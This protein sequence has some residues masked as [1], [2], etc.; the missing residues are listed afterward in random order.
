MTQHANQALPCRLLLFLQGQAHVCQQQQRMRHAILAECGF[1][2]QPSRK[3]GAKRM[4]GV[5]LCIQQIFKPQLAGAAADAPG[6]RQAQQLQPGVVHQLQHV[7]RSKA[8]SGVCI[9]SNMRATSAVD[10]RERTRCFC[11]RSASAFTSA[12]SSP[13]HPALLRRA[14]GTSIALAQ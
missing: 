10:S 11:K 14:H 7:L 2:Q 8:N 13:S 3:A 4:R 1:A 5:I 6:V 12:A 9:T